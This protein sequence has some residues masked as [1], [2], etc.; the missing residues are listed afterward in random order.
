MSEASSAIFTVFIL[1]YC[2]KKS[3]AAKFYLAESPIRN[4]PKAKLI[5]VPVRLCKFC[6]RIASKIYEP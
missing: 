2:V 5:I 6:K 1:N 4:E 3:T